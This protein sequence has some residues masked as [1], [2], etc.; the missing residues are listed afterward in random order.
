M[1]RLS[2]TQVLPIGIDIGA[3]SIKMLQLRV[4]GD[5]LEVACAARIATPPASS[6]DPQSRTVAAIEA[7]RRALEENEF[8]G[9]SAIVALPREMVHLKNLRLPPMP[10]AETAAALEF[11]ARSLFPFEIEQ[12]TLCHIIAGEVR[13][14]ADLKQELIVLAARKS[15]IEQY[16]EQLH[17]GGLV[18]ESIDYEPC[19]AYRSIERFMRR[20]EDELDVHV[21]VDVGLRRTQVTI[22]RG[23]EISMIKPIEIGGQHLRD[24]VARKLGITAE[25]AVGLRRRIAESALQQPDGD[26]DPVRHAVYDVTRAI[27]EELARE[28]SLCLRYYSVTFR[29]ARPAK[30]R[31]IGGEGADP[32]ILRILNAALSIPVETGKA[33]QNVECHRMRPALRQGPMCE[34]AVAMGLSLKGTDRYFAGR[35]GRARG[36]A[37]PAL[38][39]EGAAESRAPALAARSLGISSGGEVACA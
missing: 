35:V 7:V 19:A 17:D 6:S 23:R 20:K 16:V 37:P 28:V 30:V 38:V 22:G 8:R 2:R 14:G 9:R 27:L 4:V 13:Q 32:Q 39:S 36:E 5:S 3:D 10:P 1:I 29:G 12:S 31:V 33:L 11:E 26:S 21:L 18:L 25:E 34:W 24:A 15:E